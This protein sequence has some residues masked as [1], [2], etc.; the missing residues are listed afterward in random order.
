VK[1]TSEVD[2]VVCTQVMM[3][4]LLTVVVCL[5]TGNAWFLGSSGQIVLEVSFCGFGV[6]RKS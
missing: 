5:L 6:E 4:G 3:V 1:E 2:E